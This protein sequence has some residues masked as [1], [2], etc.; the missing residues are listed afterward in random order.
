MSIVPSM[1]DLFPAC[2]RVLESKLMPMRYND[3]T[4]EAIDLLGYS[5][6][7]VAM[8]K[9]SE[10][11]REKLPMHRQH[12]VVYLEK[13][14]CLMARRRWFQNQQLDLFNSSAKDTA[15]TIEGNVTSGIEG[16]YV[17]LM[18]TQGNMQEKTDMHTR[19]KG[20]VIEQ[21]VTDWFREN[22]PE[23]YRPASNAG[24]WEKWSKED[25][26]LKIPGKLIAVDV[27]SVSRRWSG[28]KIVLRKRTT[29]LH[30][31]ARIA[32]NGRDVQLVGTMLGA[33]W[34]HDIAPEE[35][36]DPRRLIVLLNCLKKGIPHNE[37]KQLAML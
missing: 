17:T 9:V 1:T 33:N 7:D 15:I 13:P 14:Y 11:V 12:G 18:R 23:F 24:D 36:N 5:V 6:K 2:V 4:K 20:L 10:D 21:H 26:F 30:M 37:L 29:D 22:Y 34:T 16:A 28:E 8:D 31:F 27:A 3:L 19:C 35:T 32:P 25:F